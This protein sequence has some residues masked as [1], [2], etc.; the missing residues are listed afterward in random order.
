M[1]EAPSI[2]GLPLV[3]QRPL[4]VPFTAVLKMVGSQPLIYHINVQAFLVGEETLSRGL[5]GW[6]PPEINENLNNRNATVFGGCIATSVYLRP[7][8]TEDED[9]EHRNV[10]PSGV[11]VGKAEVAF[12]SFHID[13]KHVDQNRHLLR[14]LIVYVNIPGT[15]VELFTHFKMPMFI[16]QDAECNAYREAIQLLWQGRSLPPRSQYVR[17][18]QSNLTRLVDYELRTSLGIK[19]ELEEFDLFF[20]LQKSGYMF[21]DGVSMDADMDVDNT[22]ANNGIDQRLQG[23]PETDEV[24]SGFGEYI[25]KTKA[26]MRLIKDNYEQK[27]PKHIC[28]VNVGRQEAETLLIGQTPGTFL[29]RFGSEGGSLVVSTLRKSG[30]VDHTKLTLSD[31]QRVTL[32]VCFLCFL[33]FLRVFLLLILYHKE[34]R[35]LCLLFFDVC[36]FQFQLIGPAP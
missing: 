34:R 17:L 10:D 15:E 18:D 30:L 5:Q 22:A 11:Y 29:V 24:V 32:E 36:F 1:V 4:Q 7:E 8:G 2:I 16:V 33:F 13:L 6:K 35:V 28:G 12:D 9:E 19:R 21:A 14:W 26:L 31:L 23:G 27:S 3:G 25:R 20:L